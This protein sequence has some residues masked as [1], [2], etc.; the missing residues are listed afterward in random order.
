[1]G[2]Q[3]LNELQTVIDALRDRVIKI[4]LEFEG[5]ENAETS[6]EVLDRL[7]AVIENIALGITALQTVLD[8]FPDVSGIFDGVDYETANTQF[9][10]VTT[11]I[12][13]LHSNLNILNTNLEAFDTVFKEFQKGMREFDSAGLSKT[14]Q[15]LTEGFAQT[16]GS[17]IPLLAIFSN[18][19]AAIDQIIT[20]TQSSEEP[21][22]TFATGLSNTQKAVEDYSGVIASLKTDLQNIMGTLSESATKATEFATAISES[23]QHLEAFKESANGLI[24]IKEDLVDTFSELKDK[25]VEANPHLLLAAVNFNNMLLPL[26]AIVSNK[27]ISGVA[28]QIGTLSEKIRDTSF[29]MDNLVEKLKKMSE[30]T[31]KLKENLEGLTSKTWTI[32]VVY[33]ETKQ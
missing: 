13:A 1:M 32:N 12:I 31:G 8:D 29:Y 22:S 4:S 16:Q 21:L 15:A 7:L 17:L 24:E 10:N 33:K 26:N 3:A 28:S 23:P 30:H 5:I 14:V 27:M 2:Y 25:L 20:T 11:S 19:A 6:L 18:L 9:V